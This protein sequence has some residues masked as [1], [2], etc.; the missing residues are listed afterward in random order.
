MKTKTNKLLT[1]ATIIIASFFVSTI[2]TFA[3]WTAPVSDPPTC[4]SGDP[5][6]DAPITTGAGQIKDGGLAVATYPS[7]ITNGFLVQYGNVGIGT[8]SP[9]SKLTI[10]GG[11]VAVGPGAV[12]SGNGSLAVGWG[13][14]R[15]T[16][17]GA[18]ALGYS[19]L[20]L[21]RSAIALGFGSRVDGVESL[22]YGRGAKVSGDYSVGFSVGGATSPVFDI[23]Q[24]NVFAI[25]NGNVGIGTLSPASKL[26]V[27]DGGIALGQ[28]ATASGQGSFAGGWGGPSATGLGSFA[29]G[30]STKALN[31]SAIALGFNATA[32]GVES[33]AYGRGMTV[34]GSRSIGFSL[35]ETVYNVTQPNVMAIMNGNVGIGDVAPQNKLT[36]RGTFAPGD[37]WNPLVYANASASGVTT[38][39]G[40]GVVGMQS[41]VLTSATGPSNSAYAFYGGVSSANDSGQAQT[42]YGERLDI[43]THP[44]DNGYGVYIRKGAASTGGTQYGIW[45][46]GADR[47]YFSGNVGIGITNPSQKLDV[48]GYV[49]G[50]TGLCIAN[51]CR[52]SW[53]AGGSPPPASVVDTNEN[54]RTVRGTVDSAGGILAGSGFSA[55][56]TGVGIYQITFS[57]AFTGT[58]S[59]TASCAPG[60][61]CKGITVN[62][63]STGAGIAT[64]NF[65]GGAGASMNPVDSPFSF[66]AVG[67]Q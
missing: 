6:C 9:A 14:P 3:D 60:T 23:T 61:G 1:L 8:L 21:N 18:I 55:V 57:T 11:G 10:D 16:G 44:N 26:T 56:R 43:T 53:P 64:Y 62:G 36:V 35:N 20:A 24:N 63:A 41:Q 17:D 58:P 42:V 67:P 25:M 54:V 28:G 37:T 2:F 33:L 4:N 29:F 52:T 31:T 40:T 66:I 22:A 49:R 34:S 51:D 50:S 48:E 45:E 15:A 32:S 47:N 65:V 46:S 39:V 38:V 7:T 27:L 12:A 19:A 13:N 30:Y 5:G 59:V